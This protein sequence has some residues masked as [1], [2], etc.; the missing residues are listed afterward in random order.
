[1]DF[2]SPSIERLDDAAA[3]DLFFTYG[4]L[5]CNEY[6]NRTLYYIALYDSTIIN[7]TGQN[8]ARRDQL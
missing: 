8:W 5:D 2:M 1:M 6:Y 4:E 3:N 7:L